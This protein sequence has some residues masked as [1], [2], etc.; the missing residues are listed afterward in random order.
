MGGDGWWDFTG[1]TAKMPRVPANMPFRKR[2]R[3]AGRTV[4]GKEN[5]MNPP[6][7]PT[8]AQKRIFLPA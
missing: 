8:L 5:I 3:M 7:M 1:P 2:Y 4:M 6:K